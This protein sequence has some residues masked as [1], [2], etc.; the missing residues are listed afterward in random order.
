VIGRSEKQVYAKVAKESFSEIPTLSLSK[1]REP[2]SNK[3][4]W[5]RDFKKS[6]ELKARG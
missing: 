5:V 1:G 2:Y 4:R 6:Q 3:D